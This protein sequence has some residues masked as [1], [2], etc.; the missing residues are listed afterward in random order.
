MKT[1]EADVET[2]EKNCGR[3]VGK[4]CEKKLKGLGRSEKALRRAWK[5]WPQVDGKKKMPRRKQ[6]SK[7][8]LRRC[9]SSLHF[10]KAILR[11]GPYHIPLF[12]AKI[13][14][15]RLVQVLIV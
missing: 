12:P 5:W 8:E 15:L 13:F 6:I 11:F 2:D 4:S 14:P 3:T 9:E 10:V 7:T 1:V